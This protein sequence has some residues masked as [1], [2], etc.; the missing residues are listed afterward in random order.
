MT[1]RA[2]ALLLCLSIACAAGGCGDDFDPYNRLTSMRVLAIR[3]EPPLPGPGET[4]TLSPLIYAPSEDPAVEFEW[5]WCPMTG[6]ADQG[7]PC[8]VTDVERAQLAQAG[9]VLP[10]FDLGR[11][12][13]ATL[14][15]AIDPVILAQLCAGVV[16]LP[17][18]PNCEG[19]FPVQVKLVV[20]SATKVETAVRELRLRFD[21]GNRAQ[22]QPL[23][24]R[25]AGQT[26]RSGRLSADLRVGRP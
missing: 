4:A 5:S 3:S 24:R 7:Y 23:D 2:P 6:P 15:H 20:R 18:L 26:G 25:P 17:Q 12:R 11:E 22:H 1:R 14:T 19:G 16:G 13:T 8:L 10:S 21:P 9:L